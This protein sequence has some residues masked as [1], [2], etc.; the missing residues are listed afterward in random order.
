METIQTQDMLTLSLS[1]FRA[2]PDPPPLCIMGVELQERRS[3]PFQAGFCSC[4]SWFLT[5]F[6]QRHALVERVREQVKP[7]CVSIS[8]SPDPGGVSGTFP[9]S[10]APSRQA[11]FPASRGQPSCWALV[12]P[13]A[14]L[15]PLTESG[16]QG[17][18]G[19]ISQSPPSP[20]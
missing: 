6:T 1:A 14:S 4:A 11:W 20:G 15:A 7:G 13:L 3:P 10:P 17:F 8:V 9:G 16:F 19:L 12:A 5:G 2:I 18:R